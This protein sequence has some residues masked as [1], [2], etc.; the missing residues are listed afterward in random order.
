MKIKM[1]F[2]PVVGKKQFEGKYIIKI[3]VRQGDPSRYYCFSHQVT[4][5]D[6]KSNSILKDLLA[7]QLS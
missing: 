3:I 7:S 2:V 1:Q 5:Q 4:I 6:G